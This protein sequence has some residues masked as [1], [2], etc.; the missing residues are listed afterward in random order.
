MKNKKKKVLIIVL[1]IVLI[2]LG[3]AAFITYRSHKNG[4]GLQGLLST[5]VGHNEE[6]LKDLPEMKFLLMGESGNLTDSIM[7]CSYDPKAQSA[8][9]LSIPRDTF[10]GKNK[11][12]ATSSDKINSIYQKKYPEKVVEAV[13]SVTGLDLKYYIAIDTKALIELVDTIGGVT[14]NVPINMDYDDTSQKLHIHLKAGEQLLDGNKTEQVLRFRHNNDGTTYPSEYGE[15]DI[16]R[17]RTQ[18]EFIK[19]TIK[20]TMQP[21]NVLKIKKFIDIANKNVDTNIDINFAKDYIPYAVNYKTENLKTEVLPGVPEKCNGVWIYTVNKKEAQNVIDEL[22]PTEIAEESNET[23]NSTNTNKVSNTTKA[24]ESSVSKKNIKIQLLNG[25]GS[26][27][28][29]NEVTTLLKDKGYNVTKTGTAQ[30]TSKTTIINRTGKSSQIISEV[31]DVLGGIGTSST[32]KNNSN[33]DI[34]IIIG[35]DYK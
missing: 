26:K 22:F 17:M 25:T 28:K 16:G 12:R 24:S 30:N 35:K 4:G 10:V 23:E 19:E 9:I 34:T 8:S 15:Q 14:F 1:S 33:V 5:M 13:N 32:G 18:R 29:L 21:H 7:V 27:S 11:N 6:T 31:K 3:V 2:I 20:Q